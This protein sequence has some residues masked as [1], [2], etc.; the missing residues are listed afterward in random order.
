MHRQAAASGAHLIRPRSTYSRALTSPASAGLVSERRTAGG[1]KM[2]EGGGERVG[3][4]GVSGETKEAQA[5]RAGEQRRDKN[6]GPSQAQAQQI[7]G[8]IEK[9]RTPH[10][11][12]QQT[13]CRRQ[14][15]RPRERHSPP[16]L[17]SRAP[18]WRPTDKGVV[19]SA[20][21]GQTGHDARAV[22]RC[23]VPPLPY[24]LLNLVL[25][26]R[27][28]RL[29]QVPAK[30]GCGWGWRCVAVRASSAAR[31]ASLLQI[32]A[33][34]VPGSTACSA[35][36]PDSCSFLLSLMKEQERRLP[37]SR[38]DLAKTHLRCERPWPWSLSPSSSALQAAA[39][40]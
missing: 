20:Q 17:R 13:Y 3:R 33:L 28:D 34:S 9:A 37:R 22:L 1:L 38:R 35:R 21:H 31:L 18:L 8:T 12:K 23:I 10:F 40:R 11:R 30:G 5:K 25:C 27:V 15:C 2:S 29:L 7:V 36:R 4:G 16:R 14:A 39:W 6:A 32:A 26:E 19:D 24:R